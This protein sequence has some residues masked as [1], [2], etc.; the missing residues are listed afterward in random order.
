MALVLLLCGAGVGCLVTDQIEF[1]TERNVAPMIFD[2]PSSVAKIGQTV[3][4]DKASR[5]M[6]QLQVKVRDENVNEPLQAR[7][8]LVSKGDPVPQFE[9]KDIPV[10]GEVVRDLAFDVQTG[11]LRDGECA[12][13]ELVV[14]GSFG[15]KTNGLYFADTTSEDDSDIDYAFWN[16]WEGEGQSRTSPEE[17]GRLA[18]SCPTNEMLLTPVTPAPMMEVSP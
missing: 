5:T 8:R 4:I 17:L 11:P 1:E 2:G 3:W 9:S 10:S 14:S 6:L 18:A 15:K 16:I 7:W 13:I 12:R